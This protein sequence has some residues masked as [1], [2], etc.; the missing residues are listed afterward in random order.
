MVVLMLPV[1]LVGSGCKKGGNTSPPKPK[2]QVELLKEPYKNEEFATGTYTQFSIY[3]KGYGEKDFDVLRDR[4]K[5]LA[6]KFEVHEQGISEFDE[7]NEKAGIEPVKVSKE[8]FEL[9]QDLVKYAKDTKGLY[10]PAVGVMTHLWNIGFPNAQIPTDATIKSTLDKVDY[11][12]IELDKKDQS[13]FLKKKGML[14]E[15]NGLGKGY[16][17]EKLLKK[18][19]DRGVTTAFVNLGGHAYTMGKNPNRKDGAWEVGIANPSFGETQSSAL[20]GILTSEHSSFNTTYYYGRYL[21]DGDKIY[22]HLLDTKTGYPIE[23]DLLS[24][25]VVGDSPARDDAY[26]NSL[27]NMGLEK[28]MKYVDDHDEMDAIFITKDKKIHISKGIPGE[29]ELLDKSFKIVEGK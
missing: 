26:S 23:T 9:V 15:S 24:V 20:V 11:Q 1:L 7:I 14:I 4:L 27:F 29:F 25:T 13:V 28:G 22:S 2:K 10:N 6:A 3:D 16:I 12:D 18:L 19:A 17:G 5:D 8:T 21:K